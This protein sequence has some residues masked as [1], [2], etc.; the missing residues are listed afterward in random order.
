MYSI[1]EMLYYL[2]FPLLSVFLLEQL[3]FPQHHNTISQTE[4]CLPI[5]TAKLVL[6]PSVVAILTGT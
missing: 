2:L 4:I 3:G 5:V 6:V 1:L